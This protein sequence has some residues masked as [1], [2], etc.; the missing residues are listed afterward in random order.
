MRYFGVLILSLVTTVITLPYRTASAQ[1]NQTPAKFEV[2]PVEEDALDPLSPFPWL[3]LSGELRERITFISDIEFNPDNEDNGAFLTQ[4]LS[5]TGDVTVSPWLRG[6]MTLLSALQEGGELSPVERNVLDLQEG[7][8]EFGNEGAFLRIGRQE[9]KLGS[10]RLVSD[11]NGTNVKRTWDGVRGDVGL[12]EWNISVFGLQEVAVDQTGVFNDDSS[13][14]GRLS[15]I[16]I[17]GLS[18][19]GNLD[20]YYLFA[21][22]EDRTTSEGT[23][24]QQRHSIGARSFGE[25]G[26]FF[27]NWEAIYQFGTQETEFG[28]L[29]IT[30][31]TI[32]ANTGYRFP[33]F[34]WSP[35]ILLSTNIASGDDEQGDGTL[36]TFDALFPRGSYFSELALLGPSNFFNVHPYIKAHP[37]DDLLIFVDVNFFWRFDIDDGLFGPPGNIIR[38]GGTSDARFVN[39]SVS[40]GA[41]WEATER[42]IVSF[43][44]THSEPGA[45]INETGPNDPIDFFEFSAS[46]KF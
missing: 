13:D 29:D 25:I 8:A 4:R 39:T 7:Y 34:T 27:W 31:W 41:E 11:R 19:I 6:R 44:Y 15:G 14:D 16:Y 28:D 23:G 5:L 10:S 43:L 26:D 3:D 20:L 18:I 1:Q 21:E 22:F 35:E 38:P 24:D 2:L 42:L 37:R 40:A 33:D 12:G 36:G 46:F 9:L 32:A 30:A 45:F 17:T